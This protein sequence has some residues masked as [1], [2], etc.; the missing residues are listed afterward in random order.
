ML[1][2][3]LSNEELGEL[4]AYEELIKREQ[5]KLELV[6]GNTA[7]VHNGKEWVKTQEGIV[8]VLKAKKEHIIFQMSSRRGFKGGVKIHLQT[9]MI[10]PIK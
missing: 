9:G 7:I 6:T 2:Q 8:K 3:K 1:K 10:Y 5:V 4:M